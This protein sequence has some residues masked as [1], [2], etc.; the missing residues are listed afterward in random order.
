MENI[1][2]LPASFIGDLVAIFAFGVVAIVV[3][4]IGFKIFD[5]LTPNLPFAEEIK[6]GNIACAVFVVGVLLS[7]AIIVAV[8]GKAILS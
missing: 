1:F 3:E 2:H 5:K 6:R 7:I 8:I 4:V